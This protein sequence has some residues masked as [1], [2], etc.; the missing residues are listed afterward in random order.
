METSQK[1]LYFFGA[2]ECNNG[3]TGDRPEIMVVTLSQNPR[4]LIRRR[5]DKRRTDRI[6][7]DR[8]MFKGVADYRFAL[9]PREHIERFGSSF[10]KASAIAG[11]VNGF[12]IDTQRALLCIDGGYR[13]EFKDDIV[14]FLG[15]YGRN[16]AKNQLHYETDADGKY[17]LV[18]RADEIAYHIYR[19]YVLE[20]PAIERYESRKVDIDFDSDAKLRSLS[21]GRALTQIVTA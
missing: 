20:D 21:R 11:L 15:G 3:G 17:H 6:I 4:H 2:D 13:P 19:M 7:L 9:I 12:G 1:Y 14:E 16:M 8:P 18:N 5:F 10:M